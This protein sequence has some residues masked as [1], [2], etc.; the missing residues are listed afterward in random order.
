[1]AQDNENRG[2]EQQEQEQLSEI[3]IAEL[4]NDE[5]KKRDKE[6]D[7]LKKAL[8]KAKLYSKAEEEEEEVLSK[9]DCL[10][11]ISDPNVSAYDYA[12]A[13]IELRERERELGNPDPFGADGEELCKLFGDVIEECNGDKN[14][15]ISIYQS[16][17]PND[18]PSIA[19]AYNKRK[20]IK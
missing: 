19:M 16:K 13:C 4:A 5:I 1:M 8:A 17:V 10:S 18:E 6:I 20:N 9:E 7:S 2:E 3:E 12:V 14:R 11:R 15:F